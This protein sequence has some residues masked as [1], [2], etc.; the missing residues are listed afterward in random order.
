MNQS[1]LS[2]IEYNLIQAALVH[3]RE[4]A[5]ALGENYNEIGYDAEYARSEE[6]CRQTNDLMRR[7]DQ[8]AQGKVAGMVLSQR[9]TTIIKRALLNFATSI[10][11]LMDGWYEYEPEEVTAM[12]GDAQAA[13][14]LADRINEEE[15]P[16]HE[17]LQ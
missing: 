2:R 8:S 13:T 5:F 11:S 3:Y 4:T 6:R 1:K 17:L 9:D 16:Q 14:T 12:L 7:L 15:H 10:A